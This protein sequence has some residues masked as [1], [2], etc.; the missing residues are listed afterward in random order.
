MTSFTQIDW[1]QWYIIKKVTILTK[2]GTDTIHAVIPK[3]YQKYPLKKLKHANVLDKENKLSWW[4]LHI[5]TP[6]DAYSITI[7]VRKTAIAE[8]I[9]EQKD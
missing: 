4:H 5:M 2:Q 7:H 8:I 6:H 9:H 1:G 3:K